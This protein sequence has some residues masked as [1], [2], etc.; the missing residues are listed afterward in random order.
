VHLG[1][2][3]YYFSVDV[4]DVFASDGRWSDA[5]KC[6]PGEDSPTH[7]DPA[8]TTPIAMSAADVSRLITWQ[9]A[10][11]FKLN[12]TFNAGG[13]N[14]TLADTFFAGAPSPASQVDWVNHT[15]DH[16]FLGCIQI[17][18][19][20]PG[21]TWK[22][23]TTTNTTPAPPNSQVSGGVYYLSKA[24]VDSDIQ[25]NLD[26]ASSRGLSG[27]AN[28]NPTELVS[29]EHSGLLVTPQQ[30][31]DSPFFVQSLTGH[32]I[33]FT[34][35]DASR[36]T[37]QRTLSNGTTR[38]VPR[39]PTNLYYNVGTFADEV[40]EYKAIYPDAPVTYATD[41]EAES[42][43]RSYIVPLE[44]RIAMT[45]VFANDPGAHFLHQ[46]NLADAGLAYPLLES[47]LASYRGEFATNAPIVDP[48]QTQAGTQLARATAWA[49][50]KGSTEAYIDPTGL[51][52]RPASGDTQV[53][54]T[55]PI[56]SSGALLNPDIDSY[57]G[58]LSRWVSGSFDVTV[59]Q[60]G[61]QLG[62]VVVPGAPT[63][64]TGAAED[65]SVTLSWSAPASNG[66]SPITGYV[67]TP[68]V[69]G[70][71]APGLALTVDASPTTNVSVTGLHNDTTYT[72]AVAARNAVGTGPESVRSGELTPHAVSPAQPTTS[73]TPT[74]QP[75]ETPS[76]APTVSLTSPG[77][78]VTLRPTV[79]FQWS[80]TAKGSPVV[81]T[82][83]FVRRAAFGKRLP[84]TWTLLRKVTGNTTTVVVRPGETLS[85]AVQAVDAAGHVSAMTAGSQPVSMPLATKAMTK[86]AGWKLLTN[87]G[88]Y[89]STALQ[90]SR[91]GAT[92]TLPKATKVTKVA[93][94]ASTGKKYGKVAVLVGGHKVA[95]VALSKRQ[96]AK[97]LIIVPPTFAARSG[98][99]VVRVK[100][101]GRPVRIQ[102]VAVL[103]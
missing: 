97:R 24:S 95:T 98:N 72:F 29:G 4:D 59:P 17:Q 41:V 15:Y 79:T 8:A 1:Y 76:D 63:G 83:V 90:S 20:A 62:S 12:M 54:I 26:W 39:H 102:G 45:H 6:T 37:A 46:S 35:S 28:F 50:A 22:C 49:G 67:I 10:N 44:T 96:A 64:V 73:A 71:A 51:H 38:T 58:E 25:Q 60:V 85:L 5:L 7:C 86:S 101:D 32:A 13:D 52:V 65:K 70:T 36:E 84:G 103:R 91:K 31:V 55:V 9:N 11:D 77:T 21:E 80:S 40:S 23:A 75:T 14:S 87:S 42:S 94:V 16:L 18:P 99:L 66:G 69:G 3:R 47:I 56:G 48:T 78:P 88:Y 61:Y 57:G 74:P 2:D 33:S 68:Y 53:P 93:L 89:A 30:P 27:A 81:A 43:Y 92:L 34:A 82:N 19:T 100:S